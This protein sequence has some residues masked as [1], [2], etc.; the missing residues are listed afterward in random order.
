MSSYIQH[1]YYI[2]RLAIQ[3]IELLIVPNSPFYISQNFAN[4]LYGT[5][6]EFLV[7]L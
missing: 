2:S 3:P 5:G 1:S 6:W 4:P 7:N